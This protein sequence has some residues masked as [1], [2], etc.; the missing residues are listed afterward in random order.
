MC[1]YCFLFST[2]YFAVE[3]EEVCASN[4]ARIISLLAQLHQLDFNSWSGLCCA[5]CSS[6]HR[7]LDSSAHPNSHHLVLFVGTT[8]LRM[9]TFS[10]LLHRSSLALV[11]EYAACAWFFG[12]LWGYIVPHAADEETCFY[13]QQG[14][15]LLIFEWVVVCC[16][17]LLF[18]I[19]CS[20][21][22]FR[23]ASF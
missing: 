14:L 18:I 23:G 9:D 19:V 22:N 17:I 13:S 11:L 1:M 12:L 7:D 6:I 16:G 10:P 5:I 2:R 20:L 8:K 21:R 15:K 4:M 3:I